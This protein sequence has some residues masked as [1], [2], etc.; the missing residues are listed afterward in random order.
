MIHSAMIVPL[1]EPKDPEPVVRTA[2]D[3]TLNMLKACKA[4]G[5]KRMT[6]TSSIAAIMNVPFDEAPDIFT[7]ENWT[8][9]TDDS[10][11]YDKGKT[12]AERAAW[13][14]VNAMAEED[15]IELTMIN[16]GMMFGPTE[17]DPGF[18]IGLFM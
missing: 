8:V 4:N 7:E 16:P 10:T 2:V 1:I 14:Y 11:A 17:V 15:R 13:D 9:V 3:G 18:A 5:V 6:M 12:C